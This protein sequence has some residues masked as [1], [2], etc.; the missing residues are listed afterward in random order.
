MTEPFQ[1]V[2][3]KPDAELAAD[4]KKEIL[5]QAAPILGILERINKAGF[6][7]NISWGMD[8]L[9]RMQITQLQIVKVY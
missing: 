9:G 2:T 6:A 4:F 5:E 8:A 1:L 3:N 7:C